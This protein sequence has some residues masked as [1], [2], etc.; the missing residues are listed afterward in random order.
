MTMVFW[1][2]TLSVSQASPT[3]FENLLL[4]S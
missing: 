4:T 3:V 2:V 1:H